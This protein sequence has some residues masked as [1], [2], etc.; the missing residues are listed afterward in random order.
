MK[1]FRIVAYTK[2]YDKIVCF[3]W[4]DITSKTTI[5]IVDVDFYNKTFDDWHIEYREV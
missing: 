1:Q 4:L 3:K 2:R 5:N